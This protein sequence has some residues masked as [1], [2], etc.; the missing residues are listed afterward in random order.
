MLNIVSCCF[1]RKLKGI[2][3]RLVEMINASA[4]FLLFAAC[5]KAL[6]KLRVLKTG[7]TIRIQCNKAQRWMLLFRVLEF[8][9]QSDKKSLMYII[10]YVFES[11]QVILNTEIV[12]F[13]INYLSCALLSSRPPNFF[14]TKLLMRIFKNKESERFYFCV[15]V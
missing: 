11:M 1:C 13:G 14:Q 6:E 12:S 3:L 9:L 5:R 7:K 4:L 10:L 8:I 15:C 2:A